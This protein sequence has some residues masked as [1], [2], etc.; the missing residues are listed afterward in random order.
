MADEKEP[1]RQEGGQGETEEPAEAQVPEATPEAETPAERIGE[2]VAEPMRGERRS[3][4]LTAGMSAAVVV[5]GAALFMAGFLTNSLLDDDLDPIEE[6]LAD[7]TGQVGAI[8]ELLG[9]AVGDGTSPTPSAS[10]PAT[11]PPVVA[12]S[13]DDD[14]FIGPEDASVTIIEFTD[15]Q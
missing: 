2:P 1:S 8:Q 7:L 10:S 15:Y 4:L 5:L 6:D 11:P 14:P 12:A 13:A 9:G 3:Y